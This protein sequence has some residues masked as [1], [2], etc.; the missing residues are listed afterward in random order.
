MT[1]VKLKSDIAA[2]LN[3]AYHGLP[4]ARR[5]AVD[6][7]QRTEGISRAQATLDEICNGRIE[8]YAKIG[9]AEQ[10]KILESALYVLLNHDIPEDEARKRLGLGE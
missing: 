1:D 4:D 9:E 5:T 6:E 10:N 3:V 8:M 2:K 7:A